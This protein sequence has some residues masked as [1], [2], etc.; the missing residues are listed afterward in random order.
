MSFWRY[1]LL[2]IEDSGN[3]KVEAFDTRDA[4]LDARND[5]SNKGDRFD[6]SFSYVVAVPCFPDNVDKLSTLANYGIDSTL[7]AP[8]EALVKDLA[9]LDPTTCG[10]RLAPLVRRARAVVDSAAA[11]DRER[12]MKETETMLGG[13]N[14]RSD[15]YARIERQV[16]AR[17]TKGY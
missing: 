5:P 1:V 2:W 16:L 13:W 6:A 3:A 7:A 12:W 10:P 11:S 15:L 17:I 8:V 9:A 4:A 14:N